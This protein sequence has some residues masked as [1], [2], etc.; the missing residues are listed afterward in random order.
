MSTYHLGKIKPI[1]TGPVFITEDQVLPEGEKVPSGTFQANIIERIRNMTLSL[2]LDILGGKFGRTLF[3]LLLFHLFQFLAI[4]VMTFFQVN[5]LHMTDRVISIGNVAFFLTMLITSTQLSKMTNLIGS[6][7]NTGLGV[8]IL[9]IYP[10][11]IVFSQNEYIFYLVSAIGGIGYG[12]TI[13][14][15]YNYLLENVPVKNKPPYL[16]WYNIIFKF[17]DFSRIDNWTFDCRKYWIGNC[18]INFCSGE[19]VGRLAHLP[20]RLETIC[21][22]IRIYGNKNCC[23]KQKSKF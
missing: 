7:K 10:A 22:R 3:L 4:P 1:S 23:S 11:G 21:A 6:Q 9:S 18:I 15:L 2:N 12:L 16:A 20:R 13:G 14:S 17:F 19:G 8:M 5:S